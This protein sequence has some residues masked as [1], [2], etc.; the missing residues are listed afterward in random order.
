MNCVR[1]QSLLKNLLTILGLVLLSTAPGFAQDET[2]PLQHSDYAKWET[3]SST[4]ISN[5]G[6]WV[7]YSVQPGKGDSTLHIRDNR[8]N[9]EYKVVRGQRARF[10]FDSQYCYYIVVPDPEVIKKLKKEKKS[11]DQ[12]PT[13]QLEILH[14]K[15]G[16][17]KTLPAVTS[18]TLPAKASGWLAYRLSDQKSNSKESQTAANATE[19]YQITPAGLKKSSA[20]A[21]ATS[22]QKSKTQKKSATQKPGKKKPKKKTPAKKKMAPKEVTAPKPSTPKKKA[23]GTTL[24]LTDVESKNEFRFANVLQFQFSEN[25]KVLAFTTS[26]DAPKDDGVCIF[27]L[28]SRKLSQVVS[29][30]G[31]YGTPVLDKKGHQ[32]AFLTDKDDYEHKMP[33]QSVYY[34]KTKQ[35]V[36]SKIVDMQTSGMP[37]HWWLSK[38][39][40]PSFSEN[41]MRIVLQTT[42]I[43][44]DRNKPAKDPAATEEPKAKLDIWHW[45]DPFLQPQQL[46]NAARER[47]R[48]YEA[49]FDIKRNKFIQIA[50]KAVPNVSISRRSP[51]RFAIGIAPD[52]YNKMRSWDYPGFN[53]VFLMDLVTGAAHKIASKSRGTPSLS[54]DGHYA[55]WWDG[56]KK[57]WY[58]LATTSFAAK[59][60]S[61]SVQPQVIDLG[62][63][64]PYPLFNELHDSP[65]APR[66]YGMAGWLPGDKAMLI[67]DRWDIWQVDPSGKEK[68][69]NLTKGFGRNNQI[70][71]R[72]VSLE[73]EQRHVD[74]A[75]T[76]YFSGLDHRTKAS[77]YLK[78]DAG[79]DSE[80]TKMLWLDE[81]VAGL[82]KAKETADVFVT[83]STFQKSPDLWSSTLDFKS[84]KRLS[85]I[86]ELQKSIDWGTAELVRWKSKSGQELDGILYKPD[87]FDPKKKYP[88]IVYFYE[89]YSDRLHTYYPP[90]AGRST[91]NFSFYVSRGYV[92]FIPDIPYT[93]GAPGQSA[94]H[95]ILPGVENLIAKGF[96][97]KKRIGMQGHSWGGY[98]TA[99]LVTQT[100]MFACAESG[101][102]VSNMT[103]AYGG[104]RWGSGM[105]RMFQYEK[106]QSRI[107]ETLW[108]AREKYIANSPLFFADKIETPLLILHNDKDTA[109]PWYQGIELFVALR[110]L[111]K[112]AWMLNYNDD[113]H[114]VMGDAN[115][116]DFAKRMQQFFDHYLKGDP[117]PEWMANGI[118]AVDKG[119]KFGFEPAKK[120]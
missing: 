90:A 36:A 112:P 4:A 99:Y 63:G 53:D 25:G 44:E 115:R 77:G 102:P 29:G 91:I 71:L 42:P 40:N 45:Q 89:R 120:K 118:P 41:G 19:S 10:S 33:S 83:R 32:L 62:K 73:P 15:S 101:A 23:N 84:L 76:M 82:R 46:L 13:S 49:I 109:V 16:K 7:S 37:E 103:S 92:V 97:D 93:I 68:P 47:N 52:A 70:R 67:Y 12:M 22:A 105:S 50:T 34:W 38:S 104:I 81:N 6:D 56:D 116:M 117:M 72:R 27:D 57:T 86:N 64:I 94:A 80:V 66:S 28:K 119:K 107:G 59:K 39:A 43:P 26:G 17:K 58:S 31:N 61:K 21:K 14:L 11:A 20:K 60:K 111:E 106:T 9:K 5:N 87:N 55:A 8:S 113:P 18:Y 88:M 114:W 96:I 30:R 51:S 2:R 35:K 3:I 95:S 1:I 85:K 108:D 48:S 74:L 24:V 65:S 79:D 69:I 110:R 78:L 54:P 75:E 98:Q 100:N